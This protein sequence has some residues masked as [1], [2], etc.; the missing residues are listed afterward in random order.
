MKEQLFR[1]DIINVTSHI[2]KQSK[3]HS[4]VPANHVY[5]FIWSFDLITNHSYKGSQ[6]LNISS[7]YNYDQS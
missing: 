5:T 3:F 7:I 4:L 2:L 6:G 1:C